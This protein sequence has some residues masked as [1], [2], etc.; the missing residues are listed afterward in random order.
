[1]AYEAG[2]ERNNA[3]PL[4]VLL[5]IGGGP[6]HFYF[7]AGGCFGLA[8]MMDGWMV[9]FTLPRM[10]AH[11]W[12][13]CCPSGIYRCVSQKCWLAYIHTHGKRIDLPGTVWWMEWLIHAHSHDHVV[14]SG[15]VE[16]W[17]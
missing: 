8:D 7:C 14:S 12:H 4:V 2:M 5:G 1:M 9:L 17:I 11:L 6:Y 15:G 13:G 3:M 10:R 16:G